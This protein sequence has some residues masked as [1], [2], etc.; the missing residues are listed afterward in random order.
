MYFSNGGTSASPLVGTFCGKTIPKLIPSHSNQMFLYFKSDMSKSGGGF[1]I[2]WSTTATGCG[3]II[4]AP[5]GSII[6]PHYP[7]P[8]NRNAECLWKISVSAGSVVQAIFTDL[9]LEN[10]ITCLMDYVEV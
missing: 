8:Y 10:H 7:E 4:T 3:G 9:D 2:I 1:K 6:S 5:E